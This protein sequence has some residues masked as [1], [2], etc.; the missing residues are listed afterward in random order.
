MFKLGI[1]KCCSGKV[2][3]EAMMCPHC[4]QPCPYSEDPFETTL[5]DI[6]A[7]LSQGKKIEAIKLFRDKNPGLGLAEA[8]NFVESL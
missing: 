1:C 7:L 4:G 6:R 2:S 3:S 8:K 5:R